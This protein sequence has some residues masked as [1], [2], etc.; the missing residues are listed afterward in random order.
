MYVLIK[1]SKKNYHPTFDTQIKKKKG[2]KIAN[3]SVKMYH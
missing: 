2:T 3:L 1:T